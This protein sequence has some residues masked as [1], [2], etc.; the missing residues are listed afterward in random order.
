M[1]KK[2]KKIQMFFLGCVPIRLLLI[3]IVLFI[4]KKYLY[5][6]SFIGFL[7]SFGFLY[8]FIFKKERGSTFNQIAW[9]NYLRPIHFLLYLIFGYLAY[10]KNQYAYIPLLLDV[11]IG[12]MSF[13]F[14]FLTD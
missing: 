13:I 12:I 4:D 7:I 2:D 1:S 8:N 9:W 11:L 10:N 14:E 5:Y 6:L 3:L